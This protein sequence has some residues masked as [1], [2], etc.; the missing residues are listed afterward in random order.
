M[1]VQ[2]KVMK[3]T[4]QAI[5]NAYLPVETGAS[6]KTFV[7]HYFFSH[8]NVFVLFL[9][10]KHVLCKRKVRMKLICPVSGGCLCAFKIASLGLAGHLD[11][12]ARVLVGLR[13]GA[14]RLSGPAFGSKGGA[15]AGGGQGGAAAA[16]AGLHGGPV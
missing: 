15:Q 11:L 5:S 3:A 1:D 2:R 6:I 13:P 7:L 8:E 16:Q 4:P 12:E 9:I 14:E 10:T